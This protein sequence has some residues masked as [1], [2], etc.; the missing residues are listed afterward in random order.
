[1]YILLN[2]IFSRINGLSQKRKMCPL[3]LDLPHAIVCL[4]PDLNHDLGL[5]AYL[6]TLTPA[7]RTLALCP[8]GDRSP[9]RPR[10]CN[11]R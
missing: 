5:L 7:G 10:A 11:V 1:M 8:P 3:P 4:Q 6:L 9:I 2:G